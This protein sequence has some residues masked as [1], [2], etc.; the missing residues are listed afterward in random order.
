[1]QQITITCNGNNAVADSY[2]AGYQGEHNATAIVYSLPDELVN[3]N[4]IYTVDVELPDGTA[5]STVINNYKLP[6]TAALTAL[7][8]TIKLQLSITN[9]GKLIQKSSVVQLSIHP[10]LIPNSTITSGDGTSI[11]SAEVNADGH[12]ILTLTDDT[13]IDCGYVVGPQ[14]VKGDTGEQGP[15]GLQGPKGDKGDNSHWRVIADVTLAEDVKT[16]E[17]TTD[18]YGEPFALTE[19]YVVTNATSTSSTEQGKFAI[20][21]NGKPLRGPDDTINAHVNI[22]KSGD[23]GRVWAWIKSLYPLISLQGAWQTTTSIDNKSVYCVQPGFKAYSNAL[24]SEGEQIIKVG[25]S[26][27]SNATTFAAGSQFIVFGR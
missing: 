6:L 26:A 2:N 27:S 9:G 3:A 8:G 13:T 12:L 17:I 11:Q 23:N 21:V 14:G 1:M 4:Y 25:I 19:L 22:G 18:T 16:I 10:S 24:F 5:I 15:Q 20:S 7:S